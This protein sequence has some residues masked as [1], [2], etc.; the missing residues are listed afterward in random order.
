M[1]SKATFRTYGLTT[2]LE[3]AADTLAT[4]EATSLYILNQAIAQ[5]IEFVFAVHQRPLPRVKDRLK[6]LFGLDAA[7][8]RGVQQY[9][10]QAGTAQK[11]AL[12]RAI[13]VDV[14]GAVEFF[15]WSSA[16]A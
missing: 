11:Y 14:T 4:D 1:R 6:E 16:P 8:G 9:Y 10:Q 2:L 12:A 13:I 3:D 5:L 7:I 15:E